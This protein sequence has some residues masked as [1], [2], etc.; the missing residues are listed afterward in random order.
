[1]HTLI[2]A[3][4]I[5]ATLAAAPGGRDV[6][7]AQ[8]YEDV[9]VIRRVASVSG[10]DLPAKLL[11]QLI[12]ENVERLRGRVDERNY[13][14]A[15]WTR[16]ESSRVEDT[17]TVKKE[18]DGRSTIAEI[19]AQAAY[20]LEISAPS[21]RYIAARNRPLQLE[22]VIVEYWNAAGH[23]KTEQVDLNR[24]ISPGEMTY[25]DLAEL[26]WNVTARLK[27]KAAEESMGHGTVELALL[28]PTLV[29]EP[30]SPYAKPTANLLALTTAVRE[31][32]ILEIRRLCD[33]TTAFFDEISR[34]A[35]GQVRPVGGAAAATRGIETSRLL[36]ELRRIEDLLTGDE[37]QKRDGMDKLHQL[38]V[39]LRP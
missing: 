35:S 2:T 38:I 33:A 30:T 11:G 27:A 22:S 34:Q 23:R 14:Y 25:L 7:V 17:K 36:A 1:M 10:D 5:T 8:V 16:Q 6:D 12:E 13:A 24:S 4:I 19:S 26:G 32:D 39:Y 31:K 37:Q 15:T 29:D 9:R 18:K 3:T 21:R 28:A 20:R